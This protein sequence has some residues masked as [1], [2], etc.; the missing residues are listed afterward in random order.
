M[1]PPVRPF[2]ASSIVSSAMR[3]V[4]YM[5]A[6]AMGRGQLNKGTYEASA[7]IAKYPATAPERGERTLPDPNQSAPIE[8]LKL[9]W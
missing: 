6:L 5:Q 3:R 9:E 8:V 1:L 4:R 7:S 2:A